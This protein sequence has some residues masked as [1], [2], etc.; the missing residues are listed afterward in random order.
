MTN[1][2][3]LVDDDVNPMCLTA[4]YLPEDKLDVTIFGNSG[5]RSH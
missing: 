1:P 5:R 3:L 2:I 4:E